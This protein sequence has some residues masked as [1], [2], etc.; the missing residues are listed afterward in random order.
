MYLSTIRFLITTILA[1][2]SAQTGG[3][4]ILLGLYD[5]SVIMVKNKR[6]HLKN[7]FWSCI[8]IGGETNKKIAT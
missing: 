7:I 1:Y 5:S 2:V 3:F 4:P 8:N 6:A